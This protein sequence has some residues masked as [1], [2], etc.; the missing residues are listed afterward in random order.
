MSIF[1]DYYD[2]NYKNKL[3]KRADSFRKIF[4]LLEQ[5]QQAGAG[6]QPARL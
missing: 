6:Y 3:A 1:L 4:E 5:K 2:A